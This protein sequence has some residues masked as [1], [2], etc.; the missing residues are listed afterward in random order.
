MILSDDDD[1]KS[2]LSPGMLPFLFNPSD[3]AQR[4]RSP[5]SID[6]VFS[7]CLRDNDV[8]ACDILPTPPSDTASGKGHPCRGTIE[9]RELNLLFRS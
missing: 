9:R 5:L 4:N 2:P 1:Y 6:T 8:N 7:H 3:V